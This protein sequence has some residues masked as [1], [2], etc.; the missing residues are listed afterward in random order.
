MKRN[1]LLIAVVF[2]LIGWSCSKV[3]TQTQPQGLKQTLQRNVADINTAIGK[4]S[5][6]KGYQILSTMIRLQGLLLR[7][8]LLKTA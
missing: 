3:D 8:Q 1:I 2:G 7:V 6:T 5:Q 4:I